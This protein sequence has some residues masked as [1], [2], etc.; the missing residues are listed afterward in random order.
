MPLRIGEHVFI[1]ERA[2]VEAAMIGSHVHIGRNVVVGEFAIVKDYVR[3][4]DGA[5]VAPHQVIPSFSIVA[6]APARVIAELPEGAVDALEL[7]EL[8]KSVGNNVAP[9]AASLPLPA[10]VPLA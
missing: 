6:G 1:G 2:V 3:L 9:S 10:S 8:Y 5:V 7:R 4:L